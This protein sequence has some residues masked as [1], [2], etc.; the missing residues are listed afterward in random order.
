VERRYKMVKKSVYKPSPL[1][2]HVKQCVQEVMEVNADNK[3]MYHKYLFIPENYKCGGCNSSEEVV[4]MRCSPINEVVRACTFCGVTQP[5]GI[6]D[7]R[8]ITI[9]DNEPFKDE[10]HVM[11]ID[12]IREFLERNKIVKP[13]IPELLVKLLKTQRVRRKV[14]VAELG[15]ETE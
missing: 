3:V 15:L 5:V 8:G 4:F 10:T 14:N 2:I 9:A 12:E 11:T 7:D 13:F 1:G 6:K